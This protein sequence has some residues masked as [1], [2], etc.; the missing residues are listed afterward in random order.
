MCWPYSQRNVFYVNNSNWPSLPGVLYQT[1]PELEFDWFKIMLDKMI[2]DY[3]SP[4][5]GDTGY[6]G[7]RNC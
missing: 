1:K 7:Q 4:A 5:Q 6:Y 3:P 2:W